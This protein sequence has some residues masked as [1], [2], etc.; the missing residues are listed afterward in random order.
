MEK[1]RISVKINGRPY[2][3]SGEKSEEHLYKVSM[4]VDRKV[5]RLMAIY[6]TM[7]TTDV[8]ILVALNL[9]DELTTLKDEQSSLDEHINRLI[10]DKSDPK[11]AMLP[12]LPQLSR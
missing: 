7:S 12:K 9:A 4:L 3:I 11:E 8:G 2:V 6:P 1:N 10:N 5:D